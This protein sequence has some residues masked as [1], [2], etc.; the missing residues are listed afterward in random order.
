MGKTRKVLAENPMLG[1]KLKTFLLQGKGACICIALQQ[2]FNHHHNFLSHASVCGLCVGVCACVWQCVCVGVCSCERDKIA[3][4]IFGET[5]LWVSKLIWALLLNTRRGSWHKSHN[6]IFMSEDSYT[7]SLIESGI[8]M[9]HEWSALQ[10]YRDTEMKSNPLEW[11]YMLKHSR[12][13]LWSSTNL[14]W[15]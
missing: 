1:F 15:H 5:F 9:Y 2:K 10:V 4:N 3:S 13:L 6:I 11:F 12:T 8:Q 14:K 7:K